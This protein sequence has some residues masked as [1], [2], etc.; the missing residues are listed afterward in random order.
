MRV[1]YVIMV[2]VNYSG[3]LLPMTHLM[4]FFKNGIFVSIA[5]KEEYR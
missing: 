1:R 5:E 3:D 2:C 4:R